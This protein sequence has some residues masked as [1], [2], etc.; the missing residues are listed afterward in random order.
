[1]HF[2]LRIIRSTRPITIHRNLP[3]HQRKKCKTGK[4]WKESSEAH[5]NSMVFKQGDKIVHFDKYNL[6][7]PSVWI[8]LLQPVVDFIDLQS[9][10]WYRNYKIGIKIADKN[11]LDP[12]FSWAR[13][14]ESSSQRDKVE[15]FRKLNFLNRSQNQ[16][17]P[18]VLP[19]MDTWNG[20]I[21]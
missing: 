8:V 3:E 6:H 17:K 15:Y 9:P 12:P 20:S 5:W 10:T 2:F 7:S 11:S 21:F 16:H 13:T 18:E 1:M 14:S 19:R 4:R